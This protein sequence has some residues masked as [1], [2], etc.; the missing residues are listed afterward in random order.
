M[1]WGMGMSADEWFEA[2]GVSHQNP[3]NK[4]IHWVCVPLIVFSTVGLLWSIPLASMFGVPAEGIFQFVNLGT[5]LVFAS[6][7]FY[8]KLGF[9]I[10][11]GMLAWSALALFGN[12][13]FQSNPVFGLSLWQSST[14]IFVVAW[15][16]QFVGHKIEGLK[17]SFFEDLQ[18]LLVGPAWLLHFIYKRLNISS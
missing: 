12:F 10:G 1:N 9:R 18:F 8:F 6:L 16:G 3:I 14:L 7:V 5:I 11:V 13:W 2:Y 15:I 17:P 4:A